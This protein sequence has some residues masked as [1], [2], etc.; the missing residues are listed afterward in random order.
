MAWQGV[1]AELPAGWSVVQASGGPDEGY[2]RADGPGEMTAEFRWKR[3][4]RQPSLQ[5][6][7]EQYLKQVKKASRKLKVEYEG[8]L[9]GGGRKPREKPVDLRFEW[10]ADRQG[11]GRLMWCR[12]CRR[13]VIAQVS[14]PKG[15]MTRSISHLV[16]PAVRDHAD[17]ESVE[18]GVY[19]LAFRM[20]KEIRLIRQRLMSGFLSLNFC[21]GPGRVI[22]ERWGL[23]EMLLSKGLVPW[24]E[25]EY[26]AELKRFR[27][28]TLAIEWGEH[29]ALITE[30]FEGGLRRVKAMVRAMM[31]PGRAERFASV[32]WHCPQTN[33]IVGVRAFGRK[34]LELARRVAETVRC[35]AQ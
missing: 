3:T 18:W 29:E 5:T 1:G 14:G 30:G 6:V 7:A 19:G 21:G 11:H 2:V 31:L 12:Q 34:P 8:A 27:G 17:S 13:T 9:A 26:L 32:V 20:P 16:L 28:E 35:H 15:Q 24:H 22:V 4:R 10:Q 25:K 33:R 23:A